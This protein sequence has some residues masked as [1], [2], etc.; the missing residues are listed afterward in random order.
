MRIAVL[1]LGICCLG[2]AMG[3]AQQKPLRFLRHVTLA[4]SCA[5]SAWD[6]QTT[7]AAIGRGGRESNGLFADPLGRPRWGRMIGFKAGLCGSLIA[8]QELNVFGRRQTRAKDEIWIGINTGLATR[9]TI[10]SVKN[11]SV[12]P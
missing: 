11:R 12:A 2:P 8:G 7:A 10:A 5:A 3:Q 6:V 1:V 9:F 4:A